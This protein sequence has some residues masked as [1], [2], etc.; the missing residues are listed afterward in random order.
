MGVKGLESIENV[1]LEMVGVVQELLRKPI[2]G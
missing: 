2:S 1:G